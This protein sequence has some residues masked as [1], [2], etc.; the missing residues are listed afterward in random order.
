MRLFAYLDYEWRCIPF[1]SI[2]DL[3]EEAQKYLIIEKR[4]YDLLTIHV[5]SE[6]REIARFPLILT[7]ALFKE[8][9]KAASFNKPLVLNDR[10]S[11]IVY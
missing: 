6:C 11:A 3:K 2:G 9:F 5:H 7:Y 4:L 8:T 10:K 1:Y